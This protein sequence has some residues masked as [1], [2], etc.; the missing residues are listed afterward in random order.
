MCN[1]SRFWFD[2]STPPGVVTNTSFFSSPFSDEHDGD[3][4]KPSQDEH[5][6]ELF[7]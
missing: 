1:D 4:V 7:L 6:N 3:T 5:I 2:E